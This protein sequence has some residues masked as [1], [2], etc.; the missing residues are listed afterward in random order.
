MSSGKSKAESREPQKILTISEEN[1]LAECITWLA[2]LK[3]PLKHTFNYE[4]DK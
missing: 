4:L 3:H 1:M 2:I